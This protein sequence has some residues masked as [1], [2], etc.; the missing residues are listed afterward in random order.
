[1]NDAEGKKVLVNW[2]LKDSNENTLHFFAADMTVIQANIGDLVKIADK[3]KWPGSSKSIHS[4]YGNIH[5]E[6]GMVYVTKENIIQGQSVS[7]KLLLAE[8]EMC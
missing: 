3:R 2:K 6:D 4:R 1:M 7:G 5:I 8:N